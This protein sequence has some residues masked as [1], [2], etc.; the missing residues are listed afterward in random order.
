MKRIFILAA[1]FYMV[2]CSQSEQTVITDAE[3]TIAADTVTL[4]DT[5]Q[6]DGVSGATNV[7]NVSSFNG[8]LMV[9]PQQHATVSLTMGGIVRSTSLMPGRYVQKGEVLA[10]LDNPEFI[11]CL[12]Y[13]SPSPRDTR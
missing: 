6:V 7:A 10:T 12:L 13:T 4:V 11:I 2:A 9:P 1:S 3:A 8:V 5:T